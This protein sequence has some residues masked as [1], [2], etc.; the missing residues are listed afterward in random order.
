MT[1]SHTGRHSLPLEVSDCDFEVYPYRTPPRTPPG[2]W[3]GARFPS[4]NGATSFSRH[5]GL[6]SPRRRWSS[7]SLSGRSSGIHSR[8]DASMP[9]PVWPLATMS[10]AGMQSMA[11]SVLIRSSGFPQEADHCECG[12]GCQRA[13]EAA[14][15]VCT[16]RE[17]AGKTGKENGGQPSATRRTRGSAP[18]QS[19]LPCRRLRCESYARTALAVLQGIAMPSL[20]ISGACHVVH[21]RAEG[22]MRDVERELRPAV[23]RGQDRVGKT[24]GLRL[25]RRFQHGAVSATSPLCHHSDVLEPLCHDAVAPHSAFDGLFQVVHDDHGRT[26]RF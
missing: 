15:S 8:K 21:A 16:R 13:S 23:D 1:L 11:N 3:S 22:L 26:S 25:L 17:P 20:P 2:A 24:G 7:A 6:R 4:C 14:L 12:T 19:I 5:P 10:G 9:P 18:P